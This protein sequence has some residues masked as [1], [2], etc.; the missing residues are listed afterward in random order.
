MKIS[1]I[2]ISKITTFSVA[3]LVVASAL[4]ACATSGP[5]FQQTNSP[6]PIEARDSGSGQVMSFRAYESSGRLY[7][8]GSAKKHALS[9]GG[10][11]D[12][13]LVDA[14]GRVI[15]EKQDSINPQHPRPGGGKRYSSSYVTSFPISEARNA[16]KIRVTF[17]SGSHS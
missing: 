9:S 10:H 16:A 13:Q 11:V 12:V 2:L 1:R 3:A 17:H 6:L 15:A 5:S 7:V 8:S 4:T 14:S